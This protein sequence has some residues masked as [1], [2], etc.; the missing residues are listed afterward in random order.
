MSF[1]LEYFKLSIYTSTPRNTIPKPSHWLDLQKI[2]WSMRSAN[3]DCSVQPARESVPF[4][5]WFA[6]VFNRICIENRI[7]YQFV[8]EAGS[9]TCAANPD[10]KCRQ[11]LNNVR[12]SAKNTY[13]KAN[14]QHVCCCVRISTPL[15][16]FTSSAVWQRL[17]W[18]WYEMLHTHTYSHTDTPANPKI[19]FNVQPTT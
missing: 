10:M 9:P 4:T 3:N 11:I 15:F 16:V 7:R 1:D 19:V 8:T 14:R 12:C 18:W 6:H 13:R 2:Q 5:D 17:W